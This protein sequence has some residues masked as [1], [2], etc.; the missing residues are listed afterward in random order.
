[1]SAPL[2]QVR[3]AFDLAAGGSGNFLTLS[4]PTKGILSGGTVT[5]VYPLAGEFLED[6]TEY[7]RSVSIS[8]GRSQELENVNAGAATVVLDNR[9]RTF[10][11][12]A[13]TS[14]SPYSGQIVPRKQV[15]ILCNGAAQFDGQVEDW[16]LLYSVDGMSEAVAKSADGLATLARQTITA[17]TA[18]PQTSGQ[19]VTAILDRPEIGWSPARRDIAV[20]VS[21]LI[22]EPIGG[23]INPQPVNALEYLRSVEDNEAGLL[24]VSKTGI[25]TFRDRD[26]LQR[27]TLTVFADDESGIPFSTIEVSYG[28]ELVRNS[29]N[30]DLISGEN[31]TVDFTSSQEDY[32]IITYSLSNSML[33]GAAEAESLADWLLTLYGV[34]RLRF[35][36]LGVS[37]H[38]LTTSQQNTV[39]GLELGD[40]VTVRYTPN[41]VG[42]QIRQAAVIDSITHNIR[43]ASHDVQFGLSFA[44][45][46]LILDSSSFGVLDQN[47]LGF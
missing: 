7:V 46:A 6:V 8:R 16:D 5:S 15:Q 40:L 12:T 27:S 29:V 22:G 23:T 34:P 28:T 14:V 35:S 36:Q 31:V 44:L 10:D 20:G 2:T 9:A 13:G 39:L 41:G 32:G 37:L 43:S 25:L 26:E 3:I 19:R 21:N 17:H 47:T 11:P 33:N 18:V 38:G 1:M 4:H 30:I 24:F 45:S 42:G